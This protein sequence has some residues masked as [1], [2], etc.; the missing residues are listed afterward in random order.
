MIKTN[1][2]GKKILH[3]ETVTFVR[4]QNLTIRIQE[5]LSRKSVIHEH[6]LTDDRQ[7][8]FKSCNIHKICGWPDSPQPCDGVMISVNFERH[9][10]LLQQKYFTASMP[11]LT[12]T[13]VIR[14]VVAPT[15]SL[16]LTTIFNQ[17]GVKTS[18]LVQGMPHRK[19]PRG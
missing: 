7:Y 12:P 14:H 9:Q 8:C 4:Q 19:N 3:Q 16:Y 1:V 10:Y 13:T 6:I 11:L 18:S 5:H 17:C 2:D 15:L